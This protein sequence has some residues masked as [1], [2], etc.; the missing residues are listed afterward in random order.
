MPK[1][2]YLDNGAATPLDKEVL[3]VMQ[4]FL[5]DLYFNPSA[6]YLPAKKVRNALDEARKKVAYWLG[7]KAQEII[8]TAGATEANNLAIKG[9]MDRFPDGNMVLSQLEHESVIEPAKQYNHKFIKVDNQGLIDCGDLRKKIDDNTVLVSIMLANN[10]IGTV[11]SFSV[12]NKVLNEIRLVRKNSKPL[13]FHSDC[14]QAGN[15]LDL[16]AAR[17]KVDLLSLNGGKLYGPKQSGC[18]FVK[19]SLQ[20]K[21]LIVGGGQEYG[22]RSGTENVAGI[23]GFSYALDKA[24]TLKRN[25]AKR[26]KQLQSYFIENLGQKCPSAQVNGSIKQRL[27]NNVHITLPATDNETTLLKL[28]QK[29]ILAAAGSACSASS[30]EPSHVLKAIGVSQKH[31]RSSIRFTLGRNTTLNDIKT[32][33]KFLTE[34]TKV[35]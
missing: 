34:I 24:Q 30:E 14:A 26:L 29:G 21:P 17:L 3:E 13:Y 4:P 27:P 12:I 18:L 6:T 5:S 1:T 15:Y 25:E 7:A 19:N 31:S 33:L 11:Q 2:I 20:L 22:L 16:H 35:N 8:F 28:E 9:V 32:T 10:E 23:I